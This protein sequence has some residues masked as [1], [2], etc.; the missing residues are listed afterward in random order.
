MMKNFGKKL[1]SSTL[2]FSMFVYSSTPVIEYII[3]ESVYFRLDNN[4]T[5]Y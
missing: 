2:L 5:D 3:E 4:G 1:I